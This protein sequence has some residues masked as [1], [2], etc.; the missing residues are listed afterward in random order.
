MKEDYDTEKTLRSNLCNL[1]KKSLKR[2]K[3]TREKT[4]S[5]NTCDERAIFKEDTNTFGID[6]VNVPKLGFDRGSLTIWTI[7]PGKL[8]LA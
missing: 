6:Q 8:Q 4:S 3:V 7:V 2:P 5:A 1:I